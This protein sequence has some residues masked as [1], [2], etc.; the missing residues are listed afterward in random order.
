MQGKCLTDC[1]VYRASVTE[2]VTGKLET[3]TGVTGNT[4]KNRWYGHRND[5]KYSKH[6]DSSKQNGHVW[7]LKDDTKNFEIDWT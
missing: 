4:F 2:T 3:F 6:R 5:M 7:N 1:V